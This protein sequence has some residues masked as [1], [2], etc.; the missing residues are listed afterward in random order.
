MTTQALKPQITNIN[1]IPMV[2]ELSVLEN[3]VGSLFGKVPNLIGALFL[4]VLGWL[5]G[6]VVAEVLKKVVRKLKLDKYF[7]MEKGPKVTDIFCSVIKWIIYLVF[8][9]SAVE[10]MGILS[11]SLY[12]QKLVSLIMGLLGGSIVILVAYLVARYMQKQVKTTKSEYSGLVSQ[13]IF[14]FIMIIAVSIAFD[15]A[16]IPNDLIN[17]II[18]I[19]VGSMGLGVAIALGLGLKDTIAR[20]AKKYEKKF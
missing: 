14:L 18:V 4:L 13:L 7:R 12:F 16:D 2:T 6:R 10:V 17:I 15:V 11:L 3:L 8:I 20:V 19:L 9:S 5:I 1:L